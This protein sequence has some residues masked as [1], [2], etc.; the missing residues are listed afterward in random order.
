M[1]IEVVVAGSWIGRL[2]PLL[3]RIIEFGVYRR[4]TDGCQAGVGEQKIFL[5]LEEETPS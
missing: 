4:R 1:E 5:W 2:Q 3:P